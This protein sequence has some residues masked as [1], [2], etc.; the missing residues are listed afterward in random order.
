MDSEFSS[1]DF[2]S[3]LLHESTIVNNLAVH[4]GAFC[5]FPFRW[6]YYYVS[7]NSTGKET[8]K[9][10]LCAVMNNFA[11]ILINQQIWFDLIFSFDELQINDAIYYESLPVCDYLDEAYPGRK[12]LPDTP[13]ERVKDKMALTHYDMVIWIHSL[14]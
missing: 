2:F 6:I 8:G 5:Q 3:N 12:L 10:H 11:L 9:T 14:E 7:N 13:E 4:R 1:S